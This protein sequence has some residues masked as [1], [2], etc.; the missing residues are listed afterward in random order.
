MRQFADN[1]GML[2][3][4]ILLLTV[5]PILELVIL[6]Q[7]HH[8]LAAWLNGGLALLVTI[9]GIL[10]TG[11]AGAT[12]AR[13]QGLS[14]LRELQERLGQGKLPGQTLLDGVLILIGAALLLT[15]G[16][17]TDLLGLSLLVPVTRA[18]FRVWLQRWAQRKLQRG[19]APVVIVTTAT[20]R[21]HQPD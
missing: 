19:D 17:L 9:G 12:L 6:L 8:A 16:F 1:W 21:D 13:F 4:L 2:L 14:V 20:P 18:G 7:V 15:P 10:A 5:V 3:Y 11:I